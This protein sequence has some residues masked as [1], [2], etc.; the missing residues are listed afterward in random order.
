MGDRGYSVVRSLAQRPPFG[1]KGPLLGHLD[2]ELTERCNNACLHCYINRPAHDVRATRREQTAGEW[3]EIL[4]QAAELGAM[5]VRFT[6]GE[7]LLR[8]DFADIYLYARRLGLKVMLFTNA[9]LITPELANLLARVPPLKKVEVSAYGMRPESYDA[10]ACVPGAFTEFRRGVEL[11][12]ER[13]VPLVI[14]SVLLPPNRNEMG[15]FEAWAAS[16]PGMDRLPAYSMFLD[17]RA[18]RDS[19]AKNQRIAALRLTPMEGL[20]LLTRDEGTYLHSMAQMAA[21]FMGPQ[22][23][24]LFD[25]GAGEAGCVDAYGMYQMCLLL[26]HPNMVY[27]L[28]RGTLRHAL[29]EV[30][31][32][33]RETRATNPA[34]LERC[35]R[36]FLKGLCEQCP[37]KSWMEHGTLDT[38]VEY[39][40]QVAHTQAR[41]LGLLADA[42][43]AWQVRDW[44]GR[45]DRLVQEAKGSRTEAF[46]AAIPSGC[47]GER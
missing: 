15:E 8:H 26:R 34:Y 39:L 32:T 40:C 47:E 2:L 5:S 18:R 33:L 35:A 13:Q 7:P 31:T 14:K 23:D 16:L 21:Q 28:K 42:E 19:P 20:A 9:R 6:G 24:R 30:F 41:Y 37:A 12:L 27:D 25:C 10:V 17:L 46:R 45:I 1:G 3:Q 11:L 38:P 43:R 22:E 44:R 36:C 29:T 4:R